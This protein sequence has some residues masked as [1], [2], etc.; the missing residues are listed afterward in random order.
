MS[1]Q[2]SGLMAWLIQRATAVYLALFLG[3]LLVF[4]T[5][6]PP[7]DHIALREWVTTPWVA[8]GLLLGVVVLLA[9]AWVG[10]RDVLIDYVHALSVRLTLLSLVAFVFIASGLWFLKAILSAGFGESAS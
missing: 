9:H 8:I 5:L 4:F 2:A 3:Y 10:V 6:S 1:R 7:A